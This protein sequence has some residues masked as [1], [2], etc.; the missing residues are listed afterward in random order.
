MHF[1]LICPQIEVPSVCMREAP[2]KV[3]LGVRFFTKIQDQ[4]KTPDH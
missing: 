4:I 2:I 1:V 3:K